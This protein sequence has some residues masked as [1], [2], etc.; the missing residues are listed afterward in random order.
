MI[1]Y[2]VIV[3]E[4][5]WF[6]VRYS[7]GSGYNDVKVIDAFNEECDAYAYAS[8]LMNRENRWLQQSQ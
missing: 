6:E 3:N 4:A 2:Y 5:G 1:N 7:V 8:Y